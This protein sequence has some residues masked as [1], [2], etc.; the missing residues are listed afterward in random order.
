MA[1][2][3]SKPPL[4]AALVGS[5][6]FLQLSAL[7][8]M[9]RRLPDAQRTDLDGQTAELADVLDE[10]RCFAMFGGAKA[11]VVRNADEFIKRFRP[12]LEDYLE[13]PSDSAML[14]LRFEK[15]PS[16]QR[17]YKRIQKIG[18]IENCDAPRDVTKWIVDRGK[19]EH[20]LT[21]DPE[22]ARML[23]DHI[24]NDLGRLDNEL[25]KLALTSNGKVDAG[26]VR[27]TVAFQREREMWDLTNALASGDRAAAL[28][29]WRQLVQLESSAEFRA[30]T[31]LA[32]WL[33][34]V[35]KALPLIARGESAWA[36][37]QAL[38][39]WP[40]E[41]QQPFVD[42]AR[43]L[44]GGG[45]ERAMDLLAEIDYQTKTGVGDAVEN[46]ERF[47]LAV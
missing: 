19:S 13:S 17:I 46:I 10:V 8:E 2:G 7:S 20:R 12:Q 37:G 3:P 32:L 38:R 36:I 11:V 39:I 35:R 16:N 6:L 28:R 21:V 22:A 5:D 40:R 31:W 30:V 14:I 44:G 4:V 42:T 18:R 47:I 15:L 43:T 29:R 23:A 33:E 25:A 27:Q 26:S 24:G 9:L 45:L 1:S 34:N 41:L